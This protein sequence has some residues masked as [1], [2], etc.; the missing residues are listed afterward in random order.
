MY[1]FIIRKQYDE[2]ETMDDLN[3]VSI[4]CDCRLLFLG[5]SKISINVEKHRCYQASKNTDCNNE[6]QNELQKHAPCF[7]RD[8]TQKAKG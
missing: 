8:S 1:A 4:E 7:E 3:L 5:C 6:I 2:T